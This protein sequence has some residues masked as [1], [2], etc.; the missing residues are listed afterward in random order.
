MF[1]FVVVNL[2]ECVVL[3]EIMLICFLVVFRKCGICVLDSDWL[4]LLDMMFCVL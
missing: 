1:V 2:V 4:M 3:V